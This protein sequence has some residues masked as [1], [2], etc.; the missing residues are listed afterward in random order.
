MKTAT[1]DR[2]TAMESETIIINGPAK[3]VTV[4][5]AD[6]YIGAHLVKHLA[7]T[8]R[9]VYGFSQNR[10]L[11]FEAEPM[12][13]HGG[14]KVPFEPAPV[15]S[16]W[17]VVCLDPHIGLDAFISRMRHLCDHLVEQEFYGRV[18]FVSSGEICFSS[19]EEITEDTI[20][21]PRTECDLALAFGE[22]ILNVMLHRK[23]NQ[24]GLLVVRLGVP[25]GDEIGMPD[26]PGMINRLI[27]DASAGKILEVTK[28]PEAKRSCTHISDI[29]G[30]IMSLLELGD[31]APSLVNIP[32]EVLTVKDIIDTVTE[33]FPTKTVC[34]PFENNDLDFYRH[35]SDARFNET[36]TYEREISF[37]SWFE[38]AYHPV[39]KANIC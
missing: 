26:A 36:L 19:Y 14:E 25:Y 11:D 31:L 2:Q 16:D 22:N 37:R 21:A 15:V 23:D 6:S 28:F 5:G 3:I 12:V 20:V 17:I 8:D 7:Q 24:A 27:R 10:D 29:C 35:L 4:Y 34:H 30:S 1:D 33:R 18:C 13:T 39:F 38:Q 9:M 32:G